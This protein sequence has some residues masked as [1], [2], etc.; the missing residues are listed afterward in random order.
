[1]D[2]ESISSSTCESSGIDSSAEELKLLEKLRIGCQYLDDQEKSLKQQI[3]RYQDEMANLRSRGSS[4]SPK[5]VST[6]MSMPSGSDASSDMSTDA[7]L[8]RIDHNMVPPYESET[9]VYEPVV[10]YIERPA[11]RKQSKTDFHREFVEDLERFGRV[12]CTEA[13]KIIKYLKTGKK[14]NIEANFTSSEASDLFR[15]MSGEITRLS[16]EKTEIEA[17]LEHVLSLVKKYTD[18]HK[19]KR[20][21]EKHLHSQMQQSQQE[22]HEIY[23]FIGDLFPQFSNGQVVCRENAKSILLSVAKCL[24]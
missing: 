20:H 14:Y 10:K 3:Y 4:G 15:K 2:F 11:S 22:C 8:Q 12:K 13:D 24:K 16:A 7:L 21:K 17:K 6:M 5:S 19:R 9:F 18:D 23:Q 1:M